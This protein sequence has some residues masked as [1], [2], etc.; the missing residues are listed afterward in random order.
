MIRASTGINPTMKIAALA[1]AAY[2]GI[3]LA[4]QLIGRS[5]ANVVDT[6]RQQQCQAGLVTKCNN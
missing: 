6:E 1:I 3:L 2:A 4:T 5:M